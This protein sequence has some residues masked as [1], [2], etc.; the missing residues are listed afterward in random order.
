MP[1]PE[2]VRRRRLRAIVGHMNKVKR[3]HRET[4]IGLLCLEY[5][6]KLPTAREYLEILILSGVIEEVGA[7]LE[8]SMDKERERERERVKTA[9]GGKKGAKKKPKPKT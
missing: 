9:K 2:D 4:Y 8:L 6:C 1:T 7:Y 3:V 5:G